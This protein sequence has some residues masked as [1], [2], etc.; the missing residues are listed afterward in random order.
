[1]RSES[2]TTSSTRKVSLNEGL[3]SYM[4]GIYNYMALGLALTGIIAFMTSENPA[5]MQAI[6][7]SPLR[8]VVLLAP[9]GVALFL[10]FRINSLKASTAQ[11]L[12]WIYAALM[13]VSLSFIFLVYTN[14]SIARTFFITAGMFGSMSLWGYSTKSD[15]TG[16]G[17]FL[18][19]GLFG[20][21]IA[22][23]VNFFIQ[24]S[25]I[26]FVISLL[27]VV[28][29]TGL[30]A[31]DTQ[32]IKDSYYEEGNTEKKSIMGAL[33]LYLDFINLFMHLLRFLGDR[34]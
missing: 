31:Y 23:V 5:M 26:S 33:M 16:M 24:S 25:S 19:M 14:A 20:I 27:G 21:I 13:G 18:M 4:L 8:W 12:F 9:V 15:L 34:R 30:T 28:I 10:S 17:S 22:S 1:M 7:G 11:L 6:F 29:F 2:T 32:I 3:R